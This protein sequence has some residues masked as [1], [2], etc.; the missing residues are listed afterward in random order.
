MDFLF[1]FSLNTEAV[2]LNNYNIDYIKPKYILQSILSP[3]FTKV[4]SYSYFKK[5]VAYIQQ[6]IYT[7]YFY[8]QGRS[9]MIPNHN[10]I[11]MIPM[12]N[13][14]APFPFV[15]YRLRY[16]DEFGHQLIP[17]VRGSVPNMTWLKVD[18]KICS[19]L[20]HAGTKYIVKI[21]RTQDT[22]RYLHESEVKIFI[23]QTLN[24]YT[25]VCY[26]EN[27]ETI[28]TTGKDFPI[29]GLDGKIRKYRIPKKIYTW[30]YSFNTS[31]EID[32]RGISHFSFR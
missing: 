16:I 19:T 1:D 11:P 5:I 2:R 20:Y 22:S 29:E 14:F 4:F 17:D 3:Y 12:T 10:I 6:F 24:Q 25:L 18:T 30:V 27:R 7:L 31:S 23:S 9:R 8:I 32:K 13:A 26:K 15:N 28:F 21:I